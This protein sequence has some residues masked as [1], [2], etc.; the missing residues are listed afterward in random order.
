MLEHLAAANSRA[1]ELIALA[2]QMFGPMALNWEYAG[3][4]F[5]NHPP[6]LS[7]EPDTSR[8]QI[9]LSLRTTEDNLQRDFQLAHEVCHLLYPSADPGHPSKPQT[10]VLNE[11]ISTYFSV[12]VV[13][14]AYGEETGMQVLENL[15]MHSPKYFNALMLTTRLMQLD[16]DAIKKVRAIQPM[17]NDVVTQDL[18]EADIGLSREEAEALTA[19]F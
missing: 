1:D 8:V 6:H 10:I 9:S 5:S 19:L 2:E 11:G 12:L 7:Y 3:V 15:E 4:T 16:P 17:I 18:L 14:D 13:N